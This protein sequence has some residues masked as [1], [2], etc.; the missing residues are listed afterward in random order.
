MAGTPAHS[1]PVGT[2]LPGPTTA[3]GATAACVCTVAPSS[4][5]APAPTSDSAP[6]VHACTI[7][8]A[9]ITAR[10]PIS[11][12]WSP[13]IFATCTTAQSPIAAP[14]PIV[15]LC[16]SPRSVAPYLRRASSPPP[17]GA[18]ARAQSVERERRDIDR[19]PRGRSRAERPL[20]TTTPRA[21]GSDDRVRVSRAG[22]SPL[23]LS[24][25]FA[26]SVG[27]SPPLSSRRGIVCAARQQ[28]VS[29]HDCLNPRRCGNAHARG[30]ATQARRHAEARGGEPGGRGGRA[31]DRRAGADRDVAEH[32]RARRDEARAAHLRH[33]RAD[34]DAARRR[35]HCGARE[36]TARAAGIG[37][38][39]GAMGAAAALRPP[40]CNCTRSVPSTSVRHEG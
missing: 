3:P 13:P 5:V 19:G 29:R 16:T 37:V 30:R 28:R 40:H 8:F 1:W 36:E 14:S 17:P 9:P 2:V 7:A 24:L 34:L 23:S 4:T 21:V 15:I 10:S 12:G 35:D 20:S 6:S 11:V 38:S 33:G 32:R 39:G 25:L 31:P 22:W 18:V 26:A 27:A